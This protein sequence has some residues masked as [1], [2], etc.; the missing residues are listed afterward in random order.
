MQ[1]SLLT[2][3]QAGLISRDQ[4]KHLTMAFI[5]LR[6]KS[7]EKQLLLNIMI[8]ID[9]TFQLSVM[10]GNWILYTNK[11]VISITLDPWQWSQ[12]SLGCQALCTFESATNLLSY[13]FFN[14][15]RILL[16]HRTATIS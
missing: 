14:E 9:I 6:E 3:W 7:A 5:E 8:I 11:P 2:V 10:C 16:N 15:Q 13:I 1:S 12:F 4:L